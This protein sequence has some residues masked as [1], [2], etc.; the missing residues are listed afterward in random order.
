LETSAQEHIC[1]HH[2]DRNFCKGFNEKNS[3]QIPLKI[4]KK[5]TK[6][7]V[8]LFWLTLTPFIWETAGSNGRFEIS[9]GI[10]ENKS[11]PKLDL[12]KTDFFWAP[13][14][15]IRAIENLL[16]YSIKIILYGT[17]EKKIHENWLK[18]KYR[19]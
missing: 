11:L 17:K 5:V 13:L 14:E 4:K 16:A 2:I 7:G 10:K 9:Q 8:G 12:N 1:W 19:I 6:L 18:N 3:I 15:T